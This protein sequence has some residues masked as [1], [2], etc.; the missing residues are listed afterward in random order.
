[1][2]TYQPPEPLIDEP[3][4]C[5]WLAIT[6]K[7]SQNW[8]AQGRGPEFVRLGRAVRYRPADVRTFLARGG[9]R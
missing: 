1:M 6:P 7:C 3:A 5:R 9:A 8:R 4:L 2:D